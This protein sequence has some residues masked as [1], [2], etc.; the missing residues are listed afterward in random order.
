VAEFTRHY[1]LFCGHGGF[2]GST[3]SGV[4][5]LSVIYSRT[6][7]HLHRDSTP[8]ILESQYQKAPLIAG[9]VGNKMK[10]T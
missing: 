5:F 10:K 7:P 3:H 4:V 1:Y 9:L 6:A 2:W 8:S